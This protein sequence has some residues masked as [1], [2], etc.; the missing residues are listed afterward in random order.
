MTLNYRFEVIIRIFL[1]F[2]ILLL[3]ACVTESKTIGEE[4]KIKDA[5]VRA[6]NSAQRAISYMEI[7]QLKTAELILKKTLKEAP[8]HS[9]AN[10]TFALLKLRLKEANKAEKYFR[11]A[12]ESDPNNST[13]AHDYGYY[14]C[15]KKNYDKAL[16]MFELAIANPLFINKGR[17]YLRAGECIF[18]K[19]K[20]LAEK[21]F[22][23]AYKENNFLSVALYR[24]AELHFSKNNPFKARAYYE[25]YAAVQ[26]ES[27]HSLYL[28]YRIEQLS[29]A[30]SQADEYKSRLLTKF[31]GSQ[32]AI[33]VRKKRKG[34]N[35]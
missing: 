12:V 23:A 29:G 13:A 2:F 15:Q 19:D 33:K 14:L 1:Y 28:A 9:A 35:G 8:K 5:N 24:L 6:D 21:Y 3:T 7:D 31:P 26:P 30:K 20:G 4:I 27:S 17:S 16:K 25:R 32:E 10:Y 34:K 22:L 11:I 18:G